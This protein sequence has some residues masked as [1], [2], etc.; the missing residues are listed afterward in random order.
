MFH[1][2]NESLVANLLLSFFP[3]SAKKTK[4]GFAALNPAPGPFA[5]H[6]QSFGLGH[7]VCEG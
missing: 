5:A 1:D 4:E 7:L 6:Q 3:T 2:S